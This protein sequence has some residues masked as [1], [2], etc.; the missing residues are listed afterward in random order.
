MLKFIGFLFMVG[1]AFALGYQMGREGPDAILKKARE[2][3][4]DVMTRA[5]ALERTTSLRTGLL[6]AKERLVQAKSD[7]LDKN[8]GKAV[9]GLEEAAK[10]LTQAKAAAEAELRPKLDVLIKKVSDL[11]VEAQALKPG[12]LTKLNES[13][14]EVD[15][16]LNR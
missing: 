8:Y 9:I 4:T 1:V 14:K 3:S 5:T 15:A 11:A 6:N 13:V 7:L 10:A 12:V 16:L 2:L